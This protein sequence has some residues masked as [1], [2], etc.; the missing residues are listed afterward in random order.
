MI[1]KSSYLK[2]VK[3]LEKIPYLS[4]TKYASKINAVKWL[5]N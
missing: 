2:M 3:L 1:I 4:S 5:F